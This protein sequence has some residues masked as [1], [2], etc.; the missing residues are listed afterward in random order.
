VFISL[1]NAL[2]DR[3]Y[4]LAVMRSLGASQMRLFGLVLAE[5]LAITGIGGILGLLMGHTALFFIGQQTSES[6]DFIQAISLDLNELWIVLTA[7]S[8][9]I[10]A[11]L[12]PAGKAYGTSIS[13]VLAEK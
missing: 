2:K 8:I 3:K 6:A 4:D 5:G 11:A 13:T 12:I 1:Y 7:C 9:G 10:A